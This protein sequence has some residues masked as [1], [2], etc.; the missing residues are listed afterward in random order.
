MA[1]KPHQ[2]VGFSYSA[3]REIY[4]LRA[5]EAGR[6]TGARLHVFGFQAILN[7]ILNSAWIGKRVREEG[8]AFVVEQGSRNNGGIAA[9]YDFIAENYS[10][11]LGDMLRGLTFVPKTHSRAIQMADLIAYSSYRRAMGLQG[12]EF[13]RHA[14]V[15]QLTRPPPAGDIEVLAPG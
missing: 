3:T 6:P 1:V 5:R 11:V 12:V 14:S 4:E 8:V 2:P 13:D 10:G 7:W 15:G 9:A